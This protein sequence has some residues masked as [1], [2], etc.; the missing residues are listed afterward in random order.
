MKRRHSLVIRAFTLI[1]LLVV[2]AIIGILMGFLLP[3]VGRARAQSMQLKCAAILREWGYAFHNYA[4]ANRGLIPHSGYR[5]RNPYS[6]INVY[7]P[8]FPQNES[9]Y[10]YA[11]P[12]LMKRK[13]WADYPLGQ[14]PTDDIWQCP[15]AEIG[16]D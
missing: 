2:I 13:S 4:A 15:L 8:I 12:P 5:T 10:L 3:T 11:L 14:K 7:C 9:S 16:P 1:E 6:F